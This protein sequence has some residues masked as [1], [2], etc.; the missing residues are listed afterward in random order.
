VSDTPIYDRLANPKV[1][2]LWA[3]SLHSENPD[4]MAA[5]AE[6]AGIEVWRCQE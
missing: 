3:A 4:E 2:I 1:R 6:A 5:R